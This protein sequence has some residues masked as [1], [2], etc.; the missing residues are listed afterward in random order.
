MEEAQRLA[1]LR[2]QA[3]QGFAHLTQTITTSESSNEKDFFLPFN[4]DFDPRN[5]LYEPSTGIITGVID[6]E[7]MN[8]MPWQFATDPPLR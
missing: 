6:F 4:P 2:F 3:R 7:F 5:M 8:P 1:K